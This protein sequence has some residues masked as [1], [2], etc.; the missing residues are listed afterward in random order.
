MGCRRRADG[1]SGCWSD[2]G[3]LL[4]GCAGKGDLNEGDFVG[5]GSFD[6]REV[7]VEPGDGT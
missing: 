6:E 2:E 7:L 3:E 5:E 1:G 4:W